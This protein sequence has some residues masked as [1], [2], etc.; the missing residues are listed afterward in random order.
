MRKWARRL[1]ESRD[2]A[3]IARRTRAGD[4][5]GAI[6]EAL[7]LSRRQVSHR[8]ATLE[9][10]WTKRREPDLLVLLGRDLAILNLIE[11]ELWE[12]FA[13][14]KEPQVR[15][16]TTVREGWRPFRRVTT[17]TNT[18]AGDPTILKVIEECIAERSELLGLGS[19]AD[20][21]QSSEEAL[22]PE[23]S[24]LSGLDM[25][26]IARELIRRY[27]TGDIWVA[28]LPRRFALDLGDS[29]DEPPTERDG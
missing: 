13:L 29:A 5:P 22:A 3:E 9:E 14:S 2:L 23:L 18:R 7:R 26:L 27:E 20:G 16:R 4:S 15:T 11:R 19:A 17:R 6:G 10:A 24:P 25:R 21:R 1:K 28:D 8:L 12:A